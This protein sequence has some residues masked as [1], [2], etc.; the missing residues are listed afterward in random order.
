MAKVAFKDEVKE[1]AQKESDKAE[2]IAVTESLLGVI[3]NN[4]ESWNEPSLSN[5]KSMIRK[6][7]TDRITYPPSI[8]EDNDSSDDK[9]PSAHPNLSENIGKTLYKR[10]SIDFSNVTLQI[11][12][13]S[14]VNTSTKLNGNIVSDQQ[15]DIPYRMWKMNAIDK[16]Q[17]V[18]TVRLDSTMNSEGKFLSPGAVVHVTSAFPVYMNYGDM[19]DMRCA[20]VLRQFTIVGRLPVP[21]RLV[22]PPVERLKVDGFKSDDE[23]LAVECKDQSSIKCNRC[24]CQLCSKH[25]IDFTICLAKFVPIHS[26]SLSKVA[27]ECV[28]VNKKLKEMSNKNKRFLLYYYYATSVY[29]FHGKG[30]CVELPDCIVSEVRRVY[31]DDDKSGK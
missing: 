17:T 28:F 16:D 5:V 26:V 4:P 8:L 3:L 13:A 20:I 6:I 22:C 27:R 2:M 29:Q 23:I 24:T 7:G 18:I 31:P 30:N 14:Y 10:E 11:T 12:A 15:K 19:Y 1:K 9:T 25:G 21:S